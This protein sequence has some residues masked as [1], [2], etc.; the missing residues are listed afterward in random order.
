MVNFYIRLGLGIVG[1]LRYMENPEEMVVLYAYTTIVGISLCCITSS[2]FWGFFNQHIEAVSALFCVT[3]AIIISWLIHC[4]TNVW[5]DKV[6]R[7]WLPANNHLFIIG[8]GGEVVLDDA[9]RQFVHWT[10]SCLARYTVLGEVTPVWVHLT[11]GGLTLWALFASVALASALVCGIGLSPLV[12]PVDGGITCAVVIVATLVCCIFNIILERMHR[13]G[14]LAKTLLAQEMKAAQMAD[15]ILNHTLKNILADVAGNIE[16]FLAGLAEDT[17]LGNSIACLRR[18]MR[19]CKERQVFLKL[20]AGEYE[21]VANV[22]RLEE[23]GQQLLC[24]R[25]VAATFPRLTV[26]MD[27][28][29][30]SLILE[31]AISNAFKHGAPENP[32]VRFTIEHHPPDSSEGQRPTRHQLRFTVKN[33][34]HPLHPVLTTQSVERLFAGKLWST[35]DVTSSALSDHVGLTHCLL[36]AQRGG[37][38][39]SLCQVDNEVTFTAVLMTDLVD[40]P[41]AR[42]GDGPAT[43]SVHMTLEAEKLRFFVLDDSQVAQRLMEY[44]IRQHFNV[45]VVRCFGAQEEHLEVF[46]DEAPNNADIVIIDQHLEFSKAYRGTELVEQLLERSFPGLICIRSA[47]DGP[48]DR[49]SYAQS[50]AHCCFGKDI[51]GAVIMAELKAEYQR[52][53]LPSISHSIS[54]LPGASSSAEEDGVPHSS[55]T[56]T[57]FNIHPRHDT[58]SFMLESTRSNT[59][60]A[61]HRNRQAWQNALVHPSSS[62]T[63]GARPASLFGVGP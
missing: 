52:H 29:L 44:H 56:A 22:V 34:S 63:S 31:N 58:S 5:A 54:V 24:G 37:L 26:Q 61:S 30:V 42:P 1:M 16:M 41:A 33:T 48:E 60:Y 12:A 8:P 6:R 39:L 23:F 47:N 21:P 35:R 4:Q 53:K 3:T 32:N 40:D 51:P 55:S 11:L 49:A 18:G 7:I 9:F 45:E 57:F 13:S 10:N 20:V 17:T 28:T 27:S 14:F 19:Y 59:M 50:G 2:H 46:L 25:R 62:P 36:A 43:T 38:T 15:S